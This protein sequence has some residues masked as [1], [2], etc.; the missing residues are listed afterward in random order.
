MA[1]PFPGMDPYLE[2]PDFWAEF[3]S[4]LIVAIAD[5][6]MPQIRPNYEVAIEK[7]IYELEP[8]RDNNLVLVGIPDVAVK[9]QNQ[10]Q[11]PIVQ[12]LATS[13]A[14]LPN[15]QPITVTLPMPEEVRQTYLRV[16]E[17]ASGE[18]VTAIEVLSPAN[19]RP[20]QGRTDYL[21]K[22]QKILASATHLIEIDLLRMPQ[23]M[24]VLGQNLQT[25][26][27]ILVSRSS[28]RPQASL[29]AFKLQDE[30][31]VIPIPLK[32]QDAEPQI[33]V[34]AI[35]A[36]IYDRAGFDYRLDYTVDPTP[37]LTETDQTWLAE[38]LAAQALR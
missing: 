17:I 21:S 1:S 5:E 28:D 13:V 8:E 27:Q 16:K 6:L 35:V 31:P 9:Q 24:P 29:Y 20:G 14:T 15:V 19:K 37:P 12:D 18:I 3:H 4:R 23:T 36:A 33:D 25:P 26:Y 32:P 34:Q 10:V 2:H 11:E 7:R 38:S 22:R 30:L